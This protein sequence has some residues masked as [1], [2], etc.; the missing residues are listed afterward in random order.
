MLSL[1][2]ILVQTDGELQMLFLLVACADVKD[3]H[4]HDHDHEFITSV[5]LTFSNDTSDTSIFKFVDLQDG[6]EATVDTIE[7]LAD[8]SYTVNVSFLNELESPV[9][10]ITP[11]IS[12]EAEEHQ[13]FYTGSVD[14]CTEGTALVAHEY[15]DLDENSLP[16]GLNNTVSTL[17]SG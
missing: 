9:E 1:F 5:E 7:L 12:D 14:G 10:D 11:E 3:A 15:L 17:N 2:Y 4:D 8:T 6:A 16:I 13:V